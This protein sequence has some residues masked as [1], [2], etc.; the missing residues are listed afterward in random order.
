M[1]RTDALLFPLR[2]NAATLRP[3]IPEAVIPGNFWYPRGSCH[4]GQNYC[5]RVCINR[6]VDSP[7]HLGANFSIDAL[8]SAAFDP[9]TFAPIPLTLDSAGNLIGNRPMLVQLDIDVLSSGFNAAH[10]ERGF[11]AMTFSLDLYGSFSNTTRPGWRANNPLVSSGGI[12][13]DLVPLWDDNMDAG[14]SGDLKYILLS[15]P[16]ISSGNP[17]DPRPLLTAGVPVKVGSIFLSWDGIGAGGVSVAPDQVAFAR[18]SDGKLQ[19]YQ[20]G[21]YSMIGGSFH[22]PGWMPPPAPV[23]PPPAPP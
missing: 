19:M 15:N 4:A 7:L 21:E 2:D 1:T 8:P 13:S 6:P 11:G 22:T 9:V 18:T 3:S 17:L 23:T 12:G 5:R 10:D 14:K 20:P 16:V